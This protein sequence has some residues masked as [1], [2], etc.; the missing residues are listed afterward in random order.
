MILASMGV[1]YKNQ[2]LMS[3]SKWPFL[4]I[5]LFYFL[6]DLS[7]HGCSLPHEPD[8]TKPRPGWVDSDYITTLLPS[9][10]DAMGGCQPDEPFTSHQPSHQ[11]ISFVLLGSSIPLQFVNVSF[12]LIFGSLEDEGRYTK[13]FLM[14]CHFFVVGDNSKEYCGQTRVN[15]PFI[16]G[17]A[18][19]CT[20]FLERFFTTFFFFLLFF[21]FLCFCS[22]SHNK[23]TFI[24]LFLGVKICIQDFHDINFALVRF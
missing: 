19:F 12:S 2:F 23:V 13:P 17:F 18:A 4:S 16:F 24:H 3:I 15:F 22:G 10:H 14:S 5:R 11:L 20:T 6:H 1:P 7:L 21:N 8:V 9:A